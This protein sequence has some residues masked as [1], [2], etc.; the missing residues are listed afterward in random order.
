MAKHVTSGGESFWTV[1]TSARARKF[2]VAAVGVLLSLVTAGLIPPDI[3]IW[4]TTIVSSLV[5]AGVFALPNKTKVPEAE[6]VEA[7][8]FYATGAKG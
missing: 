3:G 1:V 4:I 7:V 5:A 2:Q 6:A 8:P